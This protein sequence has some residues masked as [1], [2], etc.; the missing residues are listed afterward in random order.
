M[1]AKLKENLCKIEYHVTGLK[2]DMGG[3]NK[4]KGKGRMWGRKNA[5]K[6]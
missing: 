6:L 5:R 2:M 3:K 4:L 1:R